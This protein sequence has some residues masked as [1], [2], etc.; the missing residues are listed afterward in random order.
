MLINCRI[1]YG[2]FLVSKWEGE[3]PNP[4]KH[5]PI[6]CPHCKRKMWSNGWRKRYIITE[7][8]VAKLIYV[9]RM[10]CPDCKFDVTVLPKLVFPFRTYFSPL[11]H[12]TLKKRFLGSSSCPAILRK[13]PVSI[14]AKWRDSYTARWRVKNNTVA[15]DIKYAFSY[16]MLLL[17]KIECYKASEIVPFSR[18][19]NPT[20]HHLFGL[21]VP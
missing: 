11:I 16:D 7:D 19:S 2:Y 10:K 13:I 17:P 3:R 12:L 21:V 6:Y 14:K 1:N 8:R 4:K 20:L 18:T 5:G 15:E 9:H